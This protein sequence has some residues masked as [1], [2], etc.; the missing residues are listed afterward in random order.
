MTGIIYKDM[1]GTAPS[2]VECILLLPGEGSITSRLHE[3]P[4]TDA[5]PSR[6]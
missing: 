1:S 6:P 5:K 2:L 3:A 4:N